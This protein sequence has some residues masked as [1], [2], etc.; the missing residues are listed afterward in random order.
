MKKA[1]S[2]FVLAAAS[3]LSAETIAIVGGTVHPVSAPEI[4]EGTVLIVDGK[5]TAVGAT[6]RVPAGTKTYDARGKHVYPSLLPSATDLGLVEIGAVRATVDTVET[7]EINPQARADFAMN[8]DSELL[9]VTRSAGV[10]VSGV[11]PTGGIVSG[12]GAVMRLEGWTREDAAIRSPAYVTVTW[13]NLSIDRSPQARFSVRIQEKR[14]D[15]AVAKLKD[16]FA[17]ARAHAKARAAEGKA[18]I[19]RHDADPRLEAL[20]PAIEGKI[21]VLV[22]AN[23]LAQIRAALAWAK[24]ENLKIV[25]GGGRDAWRAAAELAAAGV[26]VILDPV[27]GLPTR[28]DEPYDAPFASAAT[29]AKAGVRFAINEGDSQ[30]ARNLA[31]HASVAMAHGLSREKALESITLEP[32]R[33]LGVADRLGS[34]E[35]GKDATLFV[36]S[37]DV[38]DFRHVVEAAWLD[39][40]PLDLSD[41]HKK[42]YER[43]RNRPKPGVR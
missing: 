3:M 33:I 6:V 32:A 13:P 26:P 30:F 14:R 23:R 9:P 24:E 25:I 36:S 37:G 42:L 22:I 15:E 1:F 39:G 40:R 21:P 34:L 19:P 18:G 27:I 38:L 17:E 2:L 8:F 10:L 35:P 4:R 16:V 41:R 11:T 20:L 29:L 12:T 43:Y 7:G 31:H 28:A 5:I